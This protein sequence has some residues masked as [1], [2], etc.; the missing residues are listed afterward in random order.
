MGG[1]RYISTTTIN[2]NI[3]KSSPCLC[4][5]VTKNDIYGCFAGRYTE[6]DPVLCTS[7]N[8]SCS[9]R[10]SVPATEWPASAAVAS[11]TVATPEG[12]RDAIETRWWTWMYHM[13]WYIYIYNI[14][15]YYIIYIYIILDKYWWLYHLVMYILKFRTSCMIDIGFTK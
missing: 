13:L 12:T 11:A 5:Q 10:W 14:Y 8:R 2:I 9:W 1:V 3:H 4:H 7:S 6:Q 15:I